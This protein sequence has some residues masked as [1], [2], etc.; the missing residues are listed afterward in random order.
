MS[1]RATRRATMLTPVIRSSGAV[2]TGGA[3]VSDMSGGRYAGWAATMPPTPGR[4]LA[5][6]LGGERRDLRGIRLVDDAR[7]RE[8]LAATADGV[9]VGDVEHRERHGQVALQVL[10]L[11]DREEDLAAL[12]TRDHRGV[13]VERAD[14]RAARRDLLRRHGDVGVEAE[15]R[16]G[17]LVGREVRLDLRLGARD[18]GLRVRDDE[19]LRR[20]L[21]RLL[22]ALGAIRQARVAGLVD[23]D[24]DGLRAG[25]V[26]L[27]AGALARDLLVLA[28]VHHERL[29]IGE[30][31]RARVDR[32]DLDALRGRL[33][34]RILERARIRDGRRDDVDLGGD[35][36]VDARHLLGD[37][38]VRVDLRDVDT[39]TAEVLLGLIHAG[40]EDRPDRACIP[41][42]DDRDLR[43]RTGSRCGRDALRAERAEARGEQ[44]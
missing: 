41:V 22:H 15:E 4:L 30:R 32:D 12:D 37:V 38:V 26:E 8:D 2:A 28:D 16:V 21:E 6:A 36:G 23:H 18:V 9:Q 34:E 27:L 11:I 1:G 40:L 10:L 33:R 39:A 25:V 20:A 3:A 7:P 29:E 19:R 31:A 14:L 42:G 24:D 44:A 13:D 35:R 5:R 43:R 17:A